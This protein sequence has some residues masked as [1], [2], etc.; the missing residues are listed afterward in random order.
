MLNR[1]AVS[2]FVDPTLSP[3]E[4]NFT[5]APGSHPVPA[6]VNGSPG[7][8]LS[9]SN[10]NAPSPSNGNV[11]VGPTDDVPE[12]VSGAVVVEVPV[13]VVVV[14][15]VVVVEPGTVV[16]TRGG[17][18]VVVVGGTL[19]VVVVGGATITTVNVALDVT[20]QPGLNTDTVCAPSDEPDGTFRD[21]DPLVVPG[22][23]STTEPSHRI[24]VAHR[25]HSD[26]KPLQEATNP[27]PTVPDRGFVDT[28]GGTCADTGAATRAVTP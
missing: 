3:D 26:G 19:G 21:D 4:L 28:D 2:A 17:V 13:V 5:N 8:M 11:V 9:L 27:L 10:V 7:W 25:S 16:G 1:P 6:A 14:D 15:P 24:W 20:L 23:M 18:V 12:G 22:T